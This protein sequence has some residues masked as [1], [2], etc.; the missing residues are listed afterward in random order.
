MTVGQMASFAKSRIAGV[1]TC[2]PAGR[3]DADFFYDRFT[4][5][6]VTDIL[7]LKEKK[8]IINAK[9]NCIEKLIEIDRFE[10]TKYVNSILSN[11]NKALFYKKYKED[12]LS[13]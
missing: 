5:E 13:L 1:V 8:Q 10:Y 12:I 11:S 6:E 4:K 7:T 3:I 2:C 9:F